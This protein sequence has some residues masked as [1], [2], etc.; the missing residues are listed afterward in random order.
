VRLAGGPDAAVP[1]EQA[2]QPK[3][4]GIMPVHDVSEQ[5]STMSPI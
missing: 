2:A 1:D 5:L 4:S 3:L